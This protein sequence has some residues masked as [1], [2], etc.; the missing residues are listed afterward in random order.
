MRT[1]SLD[2]AK[3]LKEKG[4]PQNDSNFFWG[5]KENEWI[6]L[7]DAFIGF[8]SERGIYYLTNE[9][10]IKKFFAAPTAEEVLGKLPY[11]VD[12]GDEVPKFLVINKLKSEYEV[13]YQNNKKYGCIDVYMNNKSLADAGAELWLYSEEKGLLK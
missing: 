12:I 7:Y 2:L 1:V 13:S 9:F 3:E 11:M 5:L 4:Y 10:Q 6:L 8:I